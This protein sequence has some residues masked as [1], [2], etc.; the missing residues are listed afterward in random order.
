MN[1]PQSDP[2]PDAP[3]LGKALSE[4]RVCAGEDGGSSH[5]ELQGEAPIQQ[6]VLPPAVRPSNRTIGSQTTCHTQPTTETGP[7]HLT[8][9]SDAHT[10]E[11]NT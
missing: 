10:E 3:A 9:K 7:V 1:R 5:R 11:P 2:V 8:S 6:T 4:L